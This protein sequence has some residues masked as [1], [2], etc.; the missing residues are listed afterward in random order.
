MCQSIETHRTEMFIY[1]FL[2]M[3]GYMHM[4]ER[5][6]EWERGKESSLY[7]V[8]S[9]P[10]PFLEY[11]STTDFKH[12]HMC[13]EYTR[14]TDLRDSNHGCHVESSLCWT[15]L[16]CCV[17]EQTPKCSFKCKVSTYIILTNNTWNN[18]F[19]FV[20]ILHSI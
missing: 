3:I 7:R 17:M 8:W 4:C 16:Y 15:V 18:I 6:E 19:L 10:I 14:L 5:E 9:W 13:S 12:S 2:F 1:L 11:S 20:F